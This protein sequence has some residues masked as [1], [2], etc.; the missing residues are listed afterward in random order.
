MKN[1]EQEWTEDDE[2]HLDHILNLEREVKNFQELKVELLTKRNIVQY[3]Y[4]PGSVVEMRNG[5]IYLIEELD[6]SLNLGSGKAS[7]A[8]CRALLKNGNFGE[9]YFS[10][11]VPYKVLALDAEDFDPTPYLKK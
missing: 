7:I 6:F 5:R 8:R 10:A 9:K 11:F 2:S 1:E 4:G 3:G